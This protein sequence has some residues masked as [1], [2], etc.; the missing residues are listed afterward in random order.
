MVTEPAVNTPLVLYTYAIIVSMGPMRFPVA[1]WY[2]APYVKVGDITVMKR[3]SVTCFEKV[4][5]NVEYGGNVSLC[6]SR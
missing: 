6:H 2:K 4:M 1:F 3:R 5:T